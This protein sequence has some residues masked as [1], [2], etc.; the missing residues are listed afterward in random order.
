VGKPEEM[1]S[2]GIS[3]CRYEGVIKIYLRA[4]KALIW[5][6]IGTPVNA[7]INPSFA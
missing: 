7:L 5:F 1:G 6:K 3:R 2:L 4:W